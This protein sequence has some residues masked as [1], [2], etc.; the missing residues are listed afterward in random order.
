MDS[1]ETAIAAVAVPLD[2]RLGRDACRAQSCGQP[3]QIVDPQVQHESLVGGKIAGVL[4]EGGKHGHPGRLLPRHLAR[5]DTQMH[6]V[7][8]GQ[9][10]RVGCAKEQ[11]AD[12][13]HRCHPG[14]LLHEKGSSL[15]TT[16]AHFGV[17]EQPVSR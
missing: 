15:R 3:G 4:R 8:L 9:R 5:G 7:P 17:S 11:A 10:L 14:P 16:L 2:P 1:G 13:R 6:R 12:P